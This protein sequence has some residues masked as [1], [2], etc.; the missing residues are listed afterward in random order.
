MKS[1]EYG[2]NF[3]Q[4]YLDQYKMCVEMADRISQRRAQANQFFMT[5]HTGLVG[6]LSLVGGLAKGDIY[7]IYACAG[8][9]GI[10]MCIAWLVTINSYRQLNS[11]KFKIIL[12]MEQNLPAAPYGDEWQVLGEGADAKKYR[13]LTTVECIVPILFIVPYLFVIVLSLYKS[14]T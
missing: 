5:A 2:S 4:H 13:Q 3:Q 12:K 14:I 7:W 1:E 10:L 6:I 8:V 11:G 9:F